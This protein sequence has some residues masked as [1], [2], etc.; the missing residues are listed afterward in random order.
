MT[1]EDRAR[2]A[3][4]EIFDRC[5][6]EDVTKPIIDEIQKTHMLSK[7]DLAWARGQ[8]ASARTEACAEFEER[9]VERAS[10][11][12]TQ[13]ET[14]GRKI[15]EAETLHHPL[16][17]SKMDLIQMSD[18]V[19]L[20]LASE[21]WEENTNSIAFKSEFT[22]ALVA[23]GQQAFVDRIAELSVAGSPPGKA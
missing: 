7:G 16:P 12:L 18:L 22:A 3:A 2:E 11:M 9:I 6:D 10:V 15:A 13:V 8:I 14:I 21:L 17:W 5:V 19:A 4:K 1:I 23:K 20:K